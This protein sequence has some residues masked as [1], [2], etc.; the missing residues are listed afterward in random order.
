MADCD[1]SPAL[2]F[3]NNTYEGWHLKSGAGPLNG[4]LPKSANKPENQG[5]FSVNWLDFT[6]PADEAPT[7]YRKVH[8]WGAVKSG[9]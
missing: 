3:H 5:I 2:N 6:T 9:T 4:E 8:F 1:I 7:G